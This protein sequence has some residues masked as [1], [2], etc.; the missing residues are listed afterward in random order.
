LRGGGDVLT[1]PIYSTAYDLE[2]FSAF[3]SGSLKFV[4]AALVM[5]FKQW[6]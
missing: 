6:G 1:A 3:G 4:A 5:A 2:I